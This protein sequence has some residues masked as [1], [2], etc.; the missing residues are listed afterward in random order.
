MAHHDNSRTITERIHISGKL[1]LQSPAHFGNGEVRGDALV[2]MSLLLDNT[3]TAPKALIPGSTIAGALRSYLRE[4]L[5]GYGKKKE[6]NDQISALFGPRRENENEEAEQSLLIVEDALACQPKTTLRDGVAINPKTGVALDSAKYDVEL[7]EAGTQFD[8]HFELLLTKDKPA[9]TIIPLVQAT[10]AGLECGEIRL[11]L[12]KR[13]GYGRCQVK[14]WTISRYQLTNPSH[15]C[16]WLETPQLKHQSDAA[17]GTLA[18]AFTQAFANDPTI[19]AAITDERQ[20]FS[21]TATFALEKSSLLIRS[22][23]G[24]ADLGADFVHLHAVDES[25]TNHPVIP[26]TS[27]AGVVR[28]RALRIVNT[29]ALETR[30]SNTSEN[31]QS[32]TVI[33][34]L[35]GRVQSKEEAEAA[36]WQKSPDKKKASKASRATF[37]E[38]IVEQGQQLYQ[39]RVRIDRFTGGAYE[40]A[41]FEEAPIYGTAQTHIGFQLHV[42]NPSKAEIGLLLLTLKDLWTGDLPVG[43]EASV[44]RGRLTGIQATIRLP[45]M[46]TGLNPL[47]LRQDQPAL[48]LNEEQRT[49]LQFY[50]DALWQQ[51]TNMKEGNHGE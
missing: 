32:N 5:D 18:N 50:V 43:G 30:V 15:L 19:S 20:Q 28:H 48:G 47:E 26:G 23:F 38:T 2:D 25:G 6:S 12:R 9:S 14:E 51:L 11:G 45:A 40:S 16:L 46:H 31:S 33:E 49:Q 21:L 10:L 4:R 42:R 39:T 41:L 8:L 27:W 34:G 29:L 3:E 36:R 22:G 7:L 13:R 1:I 17:T 24:E 37:D 35:F 44:G